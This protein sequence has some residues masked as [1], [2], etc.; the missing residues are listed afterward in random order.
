MHFATYLPIP[1]ELMDMWLM[2]DTL[3]ALVLYKRLPHKLLDGTR[4]TPSYKSAKNIFKAVEHG[5][6]IPTV[7]QTGYRL[8][9]EQE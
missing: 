1:N 2:G 5:I 3:R 7:I 9:A 8:V 6:T 4:V